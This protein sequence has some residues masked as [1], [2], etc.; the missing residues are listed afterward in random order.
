MA[1]KTFSLE[2]ANQ[3]LDSIKNHVEDI[4][5]INKKILHTSKDVET[6]FDIWGNTV[7]EKNNPDN[8]LY[9]EMIER[10]AFL[11]EELKM[12]I[13]EVEET[14]CYIK[15]L[16]LGLIDFP[17]EHQGKTVLLCWKVGED[18]IRH[19]HD[20]HAG[21]SSRKPIEDLKPVSKEQ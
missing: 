14:G 4:V 20:I 16:K 7:M 6:L 17:Y 19:W 3:I 10:G 12:K 8:N 1:K 21:F 11:S 2:E 5:E 15:D 18:E 9:I 13:N